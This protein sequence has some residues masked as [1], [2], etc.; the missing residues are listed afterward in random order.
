MK[1]ELQSLSPNQRFALNVFVPFLYLFPLLV[2]YFSP[3]NFG[4]GN[5]Q[6]VFLALG[7]GLAGLVLWILG[8]VQLGKSF[9]VLPGSDALVSKGVYRY[10]RHPIYIGIV[11]TLFGLL[12]ACGSTFGMVYL[13]LF[14]IPLNIFR[15]WNEDRALMEKFGESYKAYSD[16]TLF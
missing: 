7:I 10:V 14:V 8:M 12:F 16:R 15:A 2:A 3:K 4:F 5:P 6:W 13:F 11:L 1:V 9:A